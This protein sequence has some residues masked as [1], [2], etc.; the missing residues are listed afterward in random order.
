MA[1]PSRSSL[2]ED[3][4]RYKNGTRWVKAFNGVWIFSEVGL[5]GQK[6]VYQRA[7]LSSG[8]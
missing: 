2:H 3:I 4:D 8:K 6:I 5:G 7:C 1:S